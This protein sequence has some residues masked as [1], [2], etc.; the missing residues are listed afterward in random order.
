MSRQQV[1]QK[2]ATPYEHEYEMVLAALAAI[3]ALNK[4]E[5]EISQHLLL[6][7]MGAQQQNVPAE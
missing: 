4:H 5:Y 1:S 7:G 6:L 3:Y 2:A